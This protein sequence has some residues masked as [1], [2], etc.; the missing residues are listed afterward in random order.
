[1]PNDKLESLSRRKTRLWILAF[2]VIV[3]AVVAS[4][5]F[6]LR[7]AEVQ[8]AAQHR[9]TFV[10][11]VADHHLGKLVLIDDGTGLDPSFYMLELNKPVPDTKEESEALFLM[12]FYVVHDHGQALSIVYTDPKTG[13]RRPMADIN[14]DDDKDILNLTL[15]NQEGVSRKIVRHENW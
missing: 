6:A 4:L 1:M 11:Y 14:Y 9:Q 8:A 2:L 5:L 7:R 12:K 10:E 13:K 3:I 15:T